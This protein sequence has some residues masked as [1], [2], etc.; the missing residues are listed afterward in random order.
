MTY[1]RILKKLQWAMKLTFI[2]FYL[3]KILNLSK[4]MFSHV[5]N[6]DSDACQAS[7]PNSDAIL[8]SEAFTRPSISSDIP[9]KRFAQLHLLARLLL[10]WN[11][12]NVSIPMHEPKIVRN[13]EMNRESIEPRKSC[14]LEIS[15]CLV[16]VRWLTILFSTSAFLTSSFLYFAFDYIVSVVQ[17]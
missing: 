4:I 11:R 5:Q 9:A 16:F 3:H 8:R 17:I 2:S 13:R 14:V 12:L 1:I 6:K 10:L 15:V 7:L